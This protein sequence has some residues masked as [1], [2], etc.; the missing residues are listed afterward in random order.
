MP[1]PESRVVEEQLGAE[2]P[3]A[4]GVGGFAGSRGGGGSGGNL[5]IA[6][7]TRTGERRRERGEQRTMTREA[8]IRR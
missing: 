6:E 8:R 7:V 4:R 1:E 5:R 3:R 2:V